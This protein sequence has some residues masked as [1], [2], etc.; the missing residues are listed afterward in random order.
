MAGQLGYTASRFTLAVQWWVD[1][2]IT[3][4]LNPLLKIKDDHSLK[5]EKVKLS[6]YK[7]VGNSY[8]GG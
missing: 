2:L 6:Y 3:I 5:I 8:N 4:K 1:N 7:S